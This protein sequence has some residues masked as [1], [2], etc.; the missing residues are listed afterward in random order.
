MRSSGP[1]P[2]AAGAEH[3]DEDG[4]DGDG[5]DHDHAEDDQS[6]HHPEAHVAH[7]A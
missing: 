4:D 1:I 7:L 5:F 2:P 6:Q 3:R